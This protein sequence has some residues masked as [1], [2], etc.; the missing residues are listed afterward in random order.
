MTTRHRKEKSVE[1]ETTT[2]EA[3]PENQATGEDA[4]AEAPEGNQSAMAGRQDPDAET[5][6]DK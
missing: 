3:A 2:D 1:E 6:Q 5:T 4:P